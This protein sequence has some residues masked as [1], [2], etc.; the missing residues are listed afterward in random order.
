MT[1]LVEYSQNKCDI[2]KS[3]NVRIDNGEYSP[4]IAQRIWGGHPYTNVY[5]VSSDIL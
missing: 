2:C 1:K 3:T 4:F 5:M